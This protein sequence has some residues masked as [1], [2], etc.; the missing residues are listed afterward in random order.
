MG[1]NTYDLNRYEERQ[2]KAIKEEHECFYIA[3]NMWMDGSIADY[4]EDYTLTK[5]DVMRL[6]ALMGASTGAQMSFSAISMALEGIT[7]FVVDRL[8]EERGYDV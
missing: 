2:E 4:L 1:V 6:S 5:D 8:M 7:R 3:Y